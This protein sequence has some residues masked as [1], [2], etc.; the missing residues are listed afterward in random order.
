MTDLVFFAVVVVVVVA[1]RMRN[2]RRVYVTE[3]QRG[4]RFVNGAFKEALGPGSYRPLFSGQNIELVDMRP[5][6]VLLEVFP[7]RDALQ[8]DSY[9]SLGLELL[10]DDPYLATKML[11]D[12]VSDSLSVTR[13]KIRAVMSHTVC[14]GGP[15]FA[16]RIAEQIT[17]S[18]NGEL[19]RLG[20]KVANV[21]ITELSPPRRTAEF[22]GGPN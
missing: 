22:R 6:P 12:Q 4:L 19:Q 3:Y 20:M 17:S 16:A 15:E 8:H 18:V 11:K 21:E 2:K 14:D 1:L 7:Y 10:V 13:D 9:V 5:Q